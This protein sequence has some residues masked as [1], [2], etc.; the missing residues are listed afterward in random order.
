MSTGLELQVLMP[1]IN[2]PFRVYWAYNPLTLNTATVTP[3][4]ITRAMFPPGGAGDFTY[5]QTVASFAPG[6]ILKEPKKT[7]RFTVSTTF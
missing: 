1:I 7:F 6:Y 4:V 2:A 5:L 3:T